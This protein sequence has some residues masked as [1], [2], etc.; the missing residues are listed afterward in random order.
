MVRSSSRGSIDSMH[1]GALQGMIKQ[2]EKMGAN[3]IIGTRFVTSSSMPGI[4]Q[5]LAYG[6]A[7]KTM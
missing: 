3:A 2:A 4:G 7:V 6:T 5:I 1:E